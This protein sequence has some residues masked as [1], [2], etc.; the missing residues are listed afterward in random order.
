[1]I[2]RR[3]APALVGLALCACRVSA[4]PAARLESQIDRVQSGTVRIAFS[5]RSGVCGSGWSWFR[6][7]GG[8]VSGTVVN[9]NWSSGRDV[10]ATC[11]GGPVRLVIVRVAGE[12]T[13]MRMYV[14][15][16]WR[17]DTGVTDL[18][19]VSAPLAG[20]YLLRLAETG[21]IKASRTA[22][23]AATVADSL[24]ASPALL[25][26][27]KDDS[28]PSEVRSSALNW[29]GEIVGDKVALS[30]DSLAYEP[31]DREVRKQAIFAMSRRPAEEA[32]PA[33]LKMAETLPDRELRK[34]AVFW[35]AQSKDPRAVRWMESRLGR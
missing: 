1:M 14:G 12:T 11:D 5:A 17:A 34:T 24:D 9:G 33:L 28:R 10:E 7:R 35:L 6:S 20:A 22:I 31:G 27:A 3:V 23:S 15:G 8:S 4:Q 2:G 30:L 19:R 25:R 16:T 26:I 18:G 13:D 29:L 32:V 21:S